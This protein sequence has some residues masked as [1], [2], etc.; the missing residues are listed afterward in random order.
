MNPTAPWQTPGSASGTSTKVGSDSSDAKTADATEERP[1]LLDDAAPAP[2]ESPNIHGFFNSP[3]KTAYVTPRGLVVQN[4]G[5]VWQ[6]IVGLVFPLGDTG[7]IKNW[8]F[9]GGIWNSVDFAEHDSFVGPWDEMDV[10]VSISC[11]IGDF[12]IAAT[13]SPWNS[14]PHAFHTEH[15]SDLK[16]SYDGKMGGDGT[17]VLHPYVDLF[18]SIAGDSTVILGRH[19]GTGYIEPGIAP[20]LNFKDFPISF[21]F[22]I[23]TQIGPSTYWDATHAFKSSAF[24]LVSA[25]INASMPLTFIPAKYGHWHADLGVTYDYLIDDAL[26]AAGG[27]ASGNTNRNVVIGSLGFGVAF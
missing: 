22:P 4:E 15:T 14:P 20:S 26:L 25:S 8:T 18:Y 5:L 3:F 2:A 27:L 21:T 1:L 9:V 11:S 7:G 24:G 17:F 19:G 6:P 12:S 10:F 16:I 23:Y 13:Y